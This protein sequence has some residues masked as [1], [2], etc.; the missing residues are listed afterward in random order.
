MSQG[1]Q[2]H[3]D[4]SAWE[5]AARGDDAVVVVVVAAALD[6][7]VASTPEVSRTP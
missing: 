1:E 5:V 3:E 2:I 7:V 4:E 6:E